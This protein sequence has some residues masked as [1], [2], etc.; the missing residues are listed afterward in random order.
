VSGLAAG[1]AWNPVGAAL[2]VLCS[3]Y[4]A[5]HMVRDARQWLESREIKRAETKR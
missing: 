2:V 4:L 1:I 3:I 5:P